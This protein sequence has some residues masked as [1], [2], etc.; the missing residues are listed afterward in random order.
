MNIQSVKQQ[1]LK[2]ETDL[3]T[4][5]ERQ[6]KL[7][8]EQTGDSARDPGDDSVADEEPAAIPDQPE[9]P[10]PEASPVPEPAPRRTG[11]LNIGSLKGDPA[12]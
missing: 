4:Q 9:T 12:S 7:G 1:L 8:R 6:T 3:S 2:L 11:S 10:A 5:Q